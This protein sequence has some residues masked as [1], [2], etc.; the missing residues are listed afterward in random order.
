MVEAIP[1]W[2]SKG[3][4][5]SAG[6]GVDIGV[7]EIAPVGSVRSKRLV[8]LRNLTDNADRADQLHDPEARDQILERVGRL[9]KLLGRK[10]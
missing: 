5:M 6:I 7:E 3:A 2:D 8:L 1:Y 4:F 10:G 9:L